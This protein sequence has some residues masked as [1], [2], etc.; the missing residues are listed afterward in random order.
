VKNCENWREKTRKTT[1]TERKWRASRGARGRP[2]RH[3][4]RVLSHQNMRNNLNW[5]YIAW[6]SMFWRFQLH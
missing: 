5:L 1:K 2:S 3:T 6:I 4:A